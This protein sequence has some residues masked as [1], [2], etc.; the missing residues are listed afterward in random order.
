MSGDP[1]EGVRGRVEG[2][3]DRNPD[4]DS[5]PVILGALLL[6][7]A[8]RPIVEDVLAEGRAK[9]P[10]AGAGSRPEAGA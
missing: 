9:R 7:P 6:D 4:A 2:Y 5:A 8:H 10:R 3:L 1:D